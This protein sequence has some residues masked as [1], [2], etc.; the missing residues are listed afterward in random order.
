MQLLTTTPPSRPWPFLI[1]VPQDKLSTLFKAPEPGKAGSADRR[2]ADSQS[3][4]SVGEGGAELP[5]PICKDGGSMSSASKS[6]RGGNGVGEASSESSLAGERDLGAPS[7]HESGVGNN[8]KE[9]QRLGKLA[10]LPRSGLGAAQASSVRSRGQG[11]GTW[12]VASV[13]KGRQSEEAN[14]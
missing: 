14:P 6:G 7:G 5:T 12:T 8:S 9:E 11:A 3:R 1:H 13:G 10:P 4:G 2:G